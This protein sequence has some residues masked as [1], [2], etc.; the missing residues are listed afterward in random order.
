VID[1]VPAVINS[2]PQ[3]LCVVF[4]FPMGSLYA[5][6]AIAAMVGGTSGFR[7]RLYKLTG[8]LFL[9]F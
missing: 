7:G 6:F 5:L 3:Q 9:A 4:I 1:L 8:I 2:Q